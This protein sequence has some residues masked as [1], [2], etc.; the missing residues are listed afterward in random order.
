MGLLLHLGKVGIYNLLCFAEAKGSLFAFQYIADG[1][2]K[3]VNIDSR[4][5]REQ[6]LSNTKT[7]SVAEFV[8]NKYT[9][10][11]K[12]GKFTLFI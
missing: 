5:H 11:Q 10:F 7:K 3:I 1:L 2:C 8:H 9:L 12:T 6:L 4:P